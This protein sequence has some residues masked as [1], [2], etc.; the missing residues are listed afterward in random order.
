MHLVFD[1]FQGIG[2][3]CA[4]GIRPFLPALVVGALGAGDVQ[5]DFAHCS[6]SFLQSTPFLLGMVVGAI[7]LALIERRLGSEKLEQ[8]PVALLVAACSIA[9]GALL[10]AGSLCR[11][12]YVIWPG[13]IGGIVCA[14]IGIA[15]TRPLLGRVRARLDSESVGALSL[16]AE[17][18]ALIAAV[19]SVLLPPV[20]VI[21]LGL[22]VWLLVAGRG[23]DE[24]KYAGLRILR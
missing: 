16:I 10:F 8:G 15:A 14:V 9:L 17:A 2:V 21:V 5:I 7:I 18:T 6:F 23:R 12:G 3:A 13:I 4:V 22:L 20:G 1:I 19:L 11:G 24:Q